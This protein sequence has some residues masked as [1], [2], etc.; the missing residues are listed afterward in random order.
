M[1]YTDT[2][3]DKKKKSQKTDTINDVDT[4]YFHIFLDIFVW[5]LVIVSKVKIIE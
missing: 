4:T 2:N 1:N 5:V 3:K